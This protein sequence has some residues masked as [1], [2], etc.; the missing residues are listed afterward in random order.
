MTYDECVKSGKLKKKVIE[1]NIVQRTMEMAKDDLETAEDS[2]SSG[3]WTWSMIQ[4]Y[5][6]MLNVARAI[7]FNDGYVEKTHYCVVEFLRYHY[8]DEL[9]EHI[10]RMDLMRK[11]RH[12]ILYDS[13]DS[14]NESSAKTRASWA[15]EFY[16][17]IK[18]EMT[19]PM[20]D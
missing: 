19:P 10:E 9:E 4:S 6:S 2:I 11:E 17:L 13:R 12:R 5:S 3:N 1:G 8:Y 16:T 20:K 7:L 15:K 14:V 18:K